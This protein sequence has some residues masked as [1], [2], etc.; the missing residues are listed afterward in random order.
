MIK[1][2]K[3]AE[4]NIP[5]TNGISRITQIPFRVKQDGEQIIPA[6]ALRG[7]FTSNNYDRTLC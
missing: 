2:E 3:K 7:E 4:P 5:E 1:K 6:H